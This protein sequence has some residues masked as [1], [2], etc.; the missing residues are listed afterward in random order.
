MDI[1][2]LSLI[3][4]NRDRDDHLARCLEGV[5]RGRRVPDETIVVAMGREGSAVPPG[6]TCV[7]SPGHG[8][9][10]ARSRNVGR[11]NARG[12]ILVFLDVDCIPS[13]DLVGALETVAAATDALVCAEVLYLTRAV[14]DDWTDQTLRAEGIVHPARTF[15]TGDVTVA[16]DP[17][18]FWSLAFAVRAD[19]YDRLGGFDEGFSGYGGEDTDLAFR[20]CGIGVPILFQGRG[21]AFH[22]RH[23]AFDPPLTHCADIVHNARRFHA[24][25]GFWPMRGW[26][27]AFAA[28]GLVAFDGARLSLLRQPT[29]AEIAAHRVPADRTF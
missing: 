10:L 9:A 3:T 1:V 19:T 29:E 16:P 14:S 27:D 15:K 25:H 22:Q 4:L 18:L 12:D 2:S 26:L 13:H 8:L 24:R 11:R 20:A 23:A 21:C 5:A 7:S 17:G 6:V 28:L